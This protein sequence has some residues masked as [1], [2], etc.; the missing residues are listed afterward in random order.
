[1]AGRACSNWR[2]TGT[3]RRSV[4]A[5]RQL[6]RVCCVLIHH[7]TPTAVSIASSAS[8]HG[9][10]VVHT[11]FPGTSRSPLSPYIPC[12]HSPV[13]TCRSWAPWPK[14]RSPWARHSLPQ[15][16]VTAT[17]ARHAVARRFCRLSHVSRNSDGVS[18][19]SDVCVK[20]L[21]LSGYSAESDLSLRCSPAKFVCS[22]SSMSS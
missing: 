12:S 7:H 18:R 5:L 22:M 20:K 2:E 21:T 8:I 4:D 15:P 13:A 6:T 19:N 16:R 9:H 17:H 1:M 11:A 14:I 10:S 3:K